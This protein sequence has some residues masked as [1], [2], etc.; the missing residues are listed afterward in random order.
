MSNSHHAAIVGGGPAGL[1]A[2]LQLGRA[3]RKTVVF[4]AG[5]RRNA[6]AAEIRGFVTR[7]GIN[8]NEF[9]RVAREQLTPYAT[10]E[11]RDV[12]VSAIE[13]T[14]D[15]FRLTSSS[16]ELTAQT[17]LLAVG[18][19]DVLPPLEG[20]EPLWGH[21]VF[22]CPY[23]HGF[24]L[25]DRRFAVYADT[26]VMVMAGPLL[27][28]WSDDVTV[29]TTGAYQ[30]TDEQRAMLKKAGV[31]LDERKVTALSG[32]GGQLREV[33]FEGGGRLKRD[34]MMFR[35]PQQQL[36]LVTS[37]GVALDELGYVKVDAMQLTSVPGLYA[38]GDLTTPMQ[39]A[40]MAAS[41]G[42][43]AESVMNH[44]VM[45]AH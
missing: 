21:T 20:L 23:C 28:A 11:V 40:I 5:P 24:E 22:T 10:V 1:S 42:T 34:A 8:P 38:A 30:V 3:R 37:L 16:G 41:Q 27:K 7:D 2:A 32:E 13:K 9:R 29:L 15:G 33:V 36:P 26:S 25:K 44:A 4:D 39:A 45:L 18:V 12:G 31:Q 14:A 43:V 6:R 35:P 19:L 17:V